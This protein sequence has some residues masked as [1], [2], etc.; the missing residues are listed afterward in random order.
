MC[1][2]ISSCF[3]RKIYLFKVRA[4]LPNGARSVHFLWKFLFELSSN[5]MRSMSE[6]GRWPVCGATIASHLAAL[7]TGNGI[8]SLHSHLLPLPW[9]TLKS[10]RFKHTLG[11]SYVL[12]TLFWSAE[13][14][15]PSR[16][17]GAAYC[18]RCQTL[19]SP[20]RL[21]RVV[22]PECFPPAPK[23]CTFITTGRGRGVR[24]HT[25]IWSHVKALTRAG[26]T[27]LSGRSLCLRCDNYRLRS[28]Q[29][30]MVNPAIANAT[31]DSD[32]SHGGAAAHTFTTPW[33]AA[34]QASWHALNCTTTHTADV[35]RRKAKRKTSTSWAATQCEVVQLCERPGWSAVLHSHRLYSLLRPALPFHE[36]FP[37][38]LQNRSETHSGY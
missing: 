34:A 29:W 3:N 11:V 19:T 7:S 26:L 32:T 1:V 35:I 14:A 24:Y 15:V 28:G 9:R 8:I 17:C 38:T 31:V 12:R 6:R 22:H 30:R 21:R 18:L 10:Q 27:L 5:K 13:C 16:F 37:A 23:C 20:R 36:I 4:K 25:V 33:T 2:H